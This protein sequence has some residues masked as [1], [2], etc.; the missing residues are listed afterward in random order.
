M[1]DLIIKVFF[2]FIFLTYWFSTALYVMP[3]NYI[4]IKAEPLIILFDIFLQQK[5]SF[6]APPPKFN[7]R[8][9]YDFEWDNGKKTLEVIKPIA[10]EKKRNAPFNSNEEIIDYVL[11]SSVIGIQNQ[12]VKYRNDLEVNT[13]DTL[14]IN[15]RVL[16]YLYKL[17]EYQT[18]LQYSKIVFTKNKIESGQCILR[19]YA[20]SIPIPKFSERN[21]KVQSEQMEGLIF[22]SKT[23]KMDKQKNLIELKP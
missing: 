11:N 6:F 21:N 23:Y 7:F 2:L 1:K 9:Y 15:N 20:T 18:L 12:I 14:N 10:E 22:K 4:R 16:A 8:L 5:W 3:S 19:F 13:R 17:P